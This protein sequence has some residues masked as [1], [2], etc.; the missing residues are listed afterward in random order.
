[1]YLRVHGQIFNF[2]PFG[3]KLDV[4]VINVIHFIFEIEVSLMQ[5]FCYKIEFE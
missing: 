2:F 4:D 1:M 3:I 5:I